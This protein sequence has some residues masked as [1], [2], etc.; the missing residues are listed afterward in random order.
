MSNFTVTVECE[1]GEEVEI[2]ID[3]NDFH[4][5]AEQKPIYHPNEKADPGNPEDCTYTGD[6][7][8]T[9]R[10]GIKIIPLDSVVEDRY[11]ELLHD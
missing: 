7:V 3:I 10:C 4:Y 8:G 5:E 11:L 2:E 9:C 1:C 6:A